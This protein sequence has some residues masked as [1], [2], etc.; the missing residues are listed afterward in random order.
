VEDRRS[1]PSAP[2]PP[3]EEREAPVETV[4]V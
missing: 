3:T 4:E 2:A 1:A